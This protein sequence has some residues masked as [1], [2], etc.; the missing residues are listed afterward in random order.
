M[1]FTQDQFIAK[2]VKSDAYVAGSKIK[3]DFGQE[4]SIL[5][6]G[7]GRKVEKDDGPAD[8]VIS[9]S[10]ADFQALADGNLNPMTA[11]MTGR[12]KVQGAMGPAM[13]LKQIFQTIR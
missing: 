5:L 1:S 7:I 2:V 13:Q 10:W 6:D 12:V 4:G 11:F 3:F 9:L 8:S